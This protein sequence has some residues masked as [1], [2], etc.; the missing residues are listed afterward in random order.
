[1]VGSISISSPYDKIVIDLGSKTTT[2][3]RIVTG[4]ISATDPHLPTTPSPYILA[5][6]ILAA[7]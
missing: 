4:V 6:I 1:M 2:D 3:S 5:V 7:S